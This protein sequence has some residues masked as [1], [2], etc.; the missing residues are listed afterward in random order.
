MKVILRNDLVG[1]G[2]RG[3]IVDEGLRALNKL[4]SE[5]VASFEG[6]FYTFYGNALG[7]PG[8]LGEAGVG[9]VLAVATGEAVL[10]FW[11]TDLS[12]AWTVK[13][14]AVPGVRP[15]AMKMSQTSLLVELESWMPESSGSIFSAMMP[16][17]S[18]S[19]RLAASA[20]DSPAGQPPSGISHS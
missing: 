14:Y 4:F 8:V 15:V 17:S 16:V 7:V 2:K 13:S 3:D 9:K 10:V 19:S 11:F 1:V 5:R 6:K 20:G 12:R 18:S